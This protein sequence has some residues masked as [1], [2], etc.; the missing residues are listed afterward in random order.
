MSVSVDL[1]LIRLPRTRAL[2]ILLNKYETELEKICDKIISCRV[3]IEDLE[4]DQ[5]GENTY[6]TRV[7]ILMAPDHDIVVTKNP[8]ES[9]RYDD[10]YTV[11]RN[12]L[13]ASQLQLKEFT[14]KEQKNLISD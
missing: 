9:N 10:F 6:R 3:T 13:H 12:T 7:D 4:P 5:Q 1:S 8:D 14:D 2:D 11:V